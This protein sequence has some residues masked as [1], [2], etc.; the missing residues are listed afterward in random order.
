MKITI[1]VKKL[2]QM[3]VLFLAIP[4]CVFFL[5]FCKLHFGILFTVALLAASYLAIKKFRDVTFDI[6]L[7]SL[8]L[9]VSILAIFLLFAGQGGFM[10]QSWD[11]HTKNAIMRDMI[12]CKWPIIYQETDN[13]LVYYLTYWFLPCLAGKF[14]GW[15]MAN[16]ILFVWSPYVLE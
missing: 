2:S 7:K 6:E 4:I 13:A 5:S 1:S 3:G 12:N 16:L 11:N 14:L 8:I 15:E 9:G 10:P